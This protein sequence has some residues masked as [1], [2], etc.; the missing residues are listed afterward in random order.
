MEKRVEIIV[1]DDDFELK[2]S[3]NKFLRQTQGKLHDIHFTMV[4]SPVDDMF[5]NSFGACIIYTPENNDMEE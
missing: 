3:I 2:S 5:V 1:S 4:P